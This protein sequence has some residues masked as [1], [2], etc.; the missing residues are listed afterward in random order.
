MP[1]VSEYFDALPTDGPAWE[2]ERDERLLFQVPDHPMGRSWKDLSPLPVYHFPATYEPL[3]FA[4][5]RGVFEGPY[6]RLEW[7]NMNGRQ[8]FYHRNTDVDEIS[9][10]VCGERTLMT[11][12]GTVELRPGD[13]VALP[14]GVAHDN[15]GREDIHLLFYLHG[16]SRKLA[17]TV[18]SGK[19][20]I[21][22]FEGWS[23]K[24]QIEVITHCLGAGH[25][26]VAVS[27]ADEALLLKAAERNKEV[28]E[29]VR[30]GGAPGE[31]EWLYAAERVWIGTTTLSATKQRKY[32]RHRC[33]DEIQYQ[34]SG[35]RTL[36]TQRGM[37]H[38]E[39]GD[40]V[41]IPFGCA[42]ASIAEGPSR[43][44][45]ILTTEP[46]PAVPEPVRHADPDVWSFLER[47]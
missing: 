20:L 33:A 34:A 39:P 7:Q 21:P 47:L 6:L 43:H 38:L 27:M 12:L 19:Y 46:T 10:Q 24:P 37:A 17:E 41:C 45:S 26:D 16:P 1:I 4:P 8:P 35:N 40:F 11:E 13:L 30:G 9:Y 15:Y 25:C 22:P 42:F 44:L 28:L 2:L 18:A 32:R 31:T 5:P 29:V 23:D 14:L 3:K 36:I